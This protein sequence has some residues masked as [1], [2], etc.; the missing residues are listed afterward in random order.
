MDVLR[1]ENAILRLHL[2]LKWNKS[3]ARRHDFFRVD[4]PI[5]ILVVNTSQN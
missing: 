4:K 2:D 5:E 3:D 1:F